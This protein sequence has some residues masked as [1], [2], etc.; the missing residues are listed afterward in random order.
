MKLI[1]QLILIL[2]VTNLFAQSPAVSD[3]SIAKKHKIYSKILEEER[4]IY[5]HV[6]EGFWGLDENPSC[7]P[8]T[9]V[10]DGESQ[11]LSTTSAIDYMSSAP[12]GNDLMP[13]TIVVGIPNTNRNRDF[14]PIK[15]KIGKDT[16]SIHLTGGGVKFLDF[17]TAELLPYLENTY[18]LCEHRT[19]IGHSL[20]GLIVFEALL[21]KREYFDNYLALDPALDF[22]EEV[23][24]EEVLDTLRTAN[25]QKEQLYIAVANTIRSFIGVENV[26]KDSSE[27]AKLTRANLKFTNMIN[28]ENWNINITHKYYPEE[29]HFSVP[30][31]ATYEAMKQFYN[32]Y[33]FKEIINYYHP[34]YANKS[35]LVEKLEMHYQ[36]ISNHLGYPVI[37][38]ES[39]INSWA[40]GL[41]H[42]ERME[43]AIDMFNLNLK[44][45]PKNASVFNTM[46]YFMMNNDKKAEAIALFEKSLTIKEDEDI[47][48]VLKSLRE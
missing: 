35:D 38:M 41:A 4:E 36:E 47:K 16:A 43:L 19:I 21:N 31:I 46:G 24:L 7:Y 5:V 14:T 32:Y 40:F 8:I 37:P 42:F 17:I 30:Y 15:A 48:D 18:S 28:A 23:F 3:Y 20:G 29:D 10:L 9:F 45:Y 12:M 27:I 22:G 44:L 2:A 11:F 33:P 1:L 6:P 13:R 26:E 25:L 39:Y 34:R